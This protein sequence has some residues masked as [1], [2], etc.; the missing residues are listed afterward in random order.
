MDGKENRDKNR[1]MAAVRLIDG[2]SRGRQPDDISESGVYSYGIISGTL[3]DP[4]LARSISE[5][6]MVPY[7]RVRPAARMIIELLLWNRQDN[8]F[9]S[10]GLS[11]FA[12]LEEIHRRW[13]YLIAI[14]HPDRHMNGL[15]SEEAAKKINE[16]YGRAVRMKSAG[17]KP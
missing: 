11:P 5:A 9:T 14:Y 8:P 7:E 6:A 1:F 17:K 12:T 15:E 3:E 2:I 4:D 13:K 10:L 16:A